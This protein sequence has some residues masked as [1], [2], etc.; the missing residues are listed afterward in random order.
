M[1]LNMADQ[2]NVC[3]YIPAD[4]DSSKNI[5]R[6]NTK[7]I[8]TEVNFV[9]PFRMMCCLR[10]STFIRKGTKFHDARKEF[11]SNTYPGVKIV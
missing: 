4:L 6:K 11:S 5:Q 1:T 10:C 3:K 8:I 2:K 9:S 7:P